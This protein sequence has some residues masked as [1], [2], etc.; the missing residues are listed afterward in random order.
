M[1]LGTEGVGWVGTKVVDGCWKGDAGRK[2]R[3]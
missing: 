3:G 1:L 2:V